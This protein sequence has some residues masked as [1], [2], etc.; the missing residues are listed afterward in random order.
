M[1]GAAPPRP[2]EEEEGEGGGG[3][4]GEGVTGISEGNKYLHLTLSLQHAI[5]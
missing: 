3:G 2:E 1:W 5:N 4:G